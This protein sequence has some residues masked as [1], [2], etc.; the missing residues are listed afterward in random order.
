MFPFTP[1]TTLRPNLFGRFLLSIF[2]WEMFHVVGRNLEG[3][4][5]CRAADYCQ[6]SIDRL[7]VNGL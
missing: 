1:H 7:R 4:A 3:Q 5:I 6:N 2:D